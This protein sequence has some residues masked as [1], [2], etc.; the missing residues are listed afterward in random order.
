MNRAYPLALWLFCLTVAFAFAQG[1]QRAESVNLETLSRQFVER[2]AKQDFSGATQRFDATMK[3]ALPEAELRKVWTSLI[4]QV[5]PFQKQGASRSENLQQYRIIFVTCQFERGALDAKIVW[6]RDNEIAGLFFV[7]SQ[8]PPPP[9]VLPSSCTEIEIRIGEGPEALPGTLTLPKK[10]G[11]FPA[12]VLVHG[13]GPSDRD[14]TVM[15]NKP[16][17]DLAWGMASR[18]V[19]VLRYDKRS[20]AHPEALLRLGGN[21]TAKEE[22]IDDALAAIS[23]LRGR[24][25][26]APRKVFVLGHSLGGT[27]A[28]RIAQADPQV[29]GLII[30]AGSTRPLEDAILE[31]TQ[32]IFAA[33]GEV[34]ADEKKYLQQI[35]AGVAQVKS[36]D[37]SPTPAQAQAQAQMILG[38]PPRYWLD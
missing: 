33:D 10:Q 11:P 23:F 31:Q 36:L 27:L 16:F 4:T 9:A 19:A 21:L 38:A 34:T 6:S 37:K 20:L 5:G 13:S 32:Y 24:S 15:A 35:E 22:V 29:A 1:P 8:P 18:G 7:P 26:I 14:E 12:V 25:E 30:M 2:L 3:R 28:P 17:R